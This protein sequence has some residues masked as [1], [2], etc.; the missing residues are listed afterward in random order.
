[1]NVLLQSALEA[2]GSRGFIYLS[3]KKSSLGSAAAD[4]LATYLPRGALGPG[5]RDRA[6]GPPRGVGRQDEAHAEVRSVPRNE[7]DAAVLGEKFPLGS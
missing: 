5:L 2:M 7:A 6:R 4:C 3:L 1:M